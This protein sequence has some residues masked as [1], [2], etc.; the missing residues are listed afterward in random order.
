[1]LADLVTNHAN[2]PIVSSNDNYS[3]NG[4]KA[5]TISCTTLLQESNKSK[6]H[7]ISDR[8]S[9]IPDNSYSWSKFQIVERNYV[10]TNDGK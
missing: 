9:D 2:L 4:N 7:A 6:V 8:L 1:M 5:H 3:N 10:P